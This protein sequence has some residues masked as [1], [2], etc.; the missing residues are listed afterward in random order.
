MYTTLSE[1]K[2]AEILKRTCE[3]LQE[4]GVYFWRNNNI[5]VFAQSN[6]GKY[7]FR[8]LPKFGKKGL[9]DIFAIKEGRLYGIEVKRPSAPLRP[10]QTKIQE[11]FLSNGAVYVVVR[12]PEQIQQLRQIFL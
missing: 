6:D 8:A 7:R 3:R 12:T 2:E 1:P 5:P 11:E 10:E 9:P 4:L